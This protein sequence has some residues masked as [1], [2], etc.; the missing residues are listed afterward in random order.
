MTYHQRDS[1][2]KAVKLPFAWICSIGA[3][4]AVARDV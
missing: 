4:T 1:V 3:D 2:I